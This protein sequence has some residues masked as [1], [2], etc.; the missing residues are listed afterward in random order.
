MIRRRIRAL[1]ILLGRRDRQRLRLK[2]AVKKVAEREGDVAAERYLVEHYRIEAE[3]TDPF[4]HWWEYADLRQQH[5]DHKIELNV[6]VRRLESAKAYAA[7]QRLKL[8]KM[9]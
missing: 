9:Q 7:A 2:D 5:E 1:W 8:E 3:K 4:T 6:T